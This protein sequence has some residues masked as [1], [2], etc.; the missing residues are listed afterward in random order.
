MNEQLAADDASVS[1]Y[2]E[3]HGI[4][5]MKWGIRRY[6]NK[7][8][9][10]TEEGRKHRGLRRKETAEE[11]A[12]RE[13]AKKTEE[14]EKLKKYV[15]EHPSKIYKHRTEFTQDE[16]N[17]LV[18]EINFDKKLKEVRDAEVQRSWNEIQQISNRIGTIKNFM[19]TAK[20]SYNLGVDVYNTMVDSGKIHGNRRLKIGEKPAEKP[21]TTYDSYKDWLKKE[22]IDMMEKYKN[23]QVTKDDIKD[24]NTVYNNLNNMMGGN[25]KKD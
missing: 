13:E 16:L 3:H 12:A 10:L 4:L 25:K 17:Q 22:N 20:N 5:G 8:G 14:H 2:L 18:N 1:P 11:K 19:E 21:D 23:G 24:W 15:R 6:Q 7:D 9:S